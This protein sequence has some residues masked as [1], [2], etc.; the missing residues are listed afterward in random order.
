MLPISSALYRPF[1]VVWRNTR[2]SGDKAVVGGEHLQVDLIG[3]LDPAY[4]L[5]AQDL[6]TQHIRVG[7]TAVIQLVVLADEGLA[8]ISQFRCKWHRESLPIV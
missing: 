5:G 2:A 3:H 8:F 1:L 7:H 4:G 6:H